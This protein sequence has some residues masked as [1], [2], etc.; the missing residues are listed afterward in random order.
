MDRVRF[1]SR[2]LL[3]AALVLMTS[4]CAAYQVGNPFLPTARILVTVSPQV[5]ESK[6]E[7]DRSKALFVYET[8]NADFTLSPYPNDTTPAVLFTDYDVT[9]RNQDGAEISS[10]TI[11]K[12]RLAATVFVNRSAGGGAGGGVGGGVGGGAGGGVP[13]GG[14]PGG[15]VGGVVG[16]GPGICTVPIV[17]ESVIR[18]AIDNGFVTLGNLVSVNPENWSSN[19]SGFVTFYGRDENQYPIKAEGTFTVNFR[20]A[21]ISTGGGN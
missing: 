21:V 6:I 8:R 2:R 17:P 15:G 11:P 1:R 19:L 4:A 20:T 10:Y 3:G 5:V 7:Y 9:Y 13:G 16:A 18:Y 14:L 12:R